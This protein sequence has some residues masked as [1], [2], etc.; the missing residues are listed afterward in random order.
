MNRWEVWSFD[1][2][3]AGAHPAI[4]ISHPDRVARSRFVN[5]LLCSTQR[6]TRTANE[7]EV[8]LDEADGF[9]WPTLCKCDLFY[10]VPRE[11]LY[12]RRGIVSWERRRTVLQRIISSCAFNAP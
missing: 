9:D 7:T 4:L 6:A 10:L 11:K 2:P 5:V 12:Q 3:G 1:F 8:L